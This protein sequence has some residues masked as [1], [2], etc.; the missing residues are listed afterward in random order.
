MEDLAPFVAL[1]AHYAKGCCAKVDY[2][3]DADWD[4]SCCYTS[5]WCHDN[6]R[7]TEKL[8]DT[9]EAILLEIVVHENAIE[10][11]SHIQ[12][13]RS[14]ECQF[15]KPQPHILQ[16]I[17]LRYN[18]LMEHVDA[19]LNFLRGI[20]ESS[21]LSSSLTMIFLSLPSP[22]TKRVLPQPNSS[23]H[24]KEYIGRK[25]LYTGYLIESSQA[26]KYVND[27]EESVRK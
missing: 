25:K 26:M 22:I 11:C 17:I 14:D 27:V 18:E 10:T 16:T 21:N 15:P 5:G 24:Q 13:H 20:M 8:G 4:L 6:N 19:P 3:Q 2:H 9:D 23:I 1:D 12:C 7:Q